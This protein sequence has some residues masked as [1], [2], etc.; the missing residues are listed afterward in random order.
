MVSEVKP[1]RFK[2]IISES[3]LQLCVITLVGLAYLFTNS[4]NESRGTYP[5]NS[6]LR[7]LIISFVPIGVNLVILIACFVVSISIGPI[8]TLFCK[9][10]PSFVA[11]I[12]HLL[13]VAN[14]VFFFELLWLFQN[15]NFSVT[16]LG[17]ALSALIQCWFLQM[18]TILLVSREFRHD[19]SNRSWWS[20]KWATAGL[21]W[22]II[23]Q[24]MREAVC[25]LSEMSYFAGDLVATHIILFA[26]IPILLIPYAD[27]WHTLMLFW[28]KPGNQ[29]RPRILSKRQKRRRRFQANLYLLIFLL[30]LILFSSIFVLP[31]IATKYFDIEFSEYI[32][33]FFHPLF[34][35]YDAPTNLKGLKKN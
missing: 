2:L 9:K 28:L 1:S 11:A 21:G 13:A 22:Y 30:G 32:P 20:G 16:V 19:R 14:H 7:I 27:K 25:K 10:F 26:Q 15:W 24:P 3:F 29:I 18:M 17:F 8:F 33:E 4:Q 31:L 35:P 34:Q 23:T 5:V 6:I 12:A